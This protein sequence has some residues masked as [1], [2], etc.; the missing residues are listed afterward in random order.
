MVIN[1]QPGYFNLSL[2]LTELVQNGG[3]VN[4]K[5]Y[6][7]SSIIP[8]LYEYKRSTRLAIRSHQCTVKLSRCNCKFYTNSFFF[9]SHAL[10]VK[11][12]S[13]SMLSNQL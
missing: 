6:K 13:G 8:R 2:N 12:S 5:N 9:L 3:Y 11:I 7:V 4:S 1:I 10:L